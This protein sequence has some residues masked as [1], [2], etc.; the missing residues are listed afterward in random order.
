MKNK[1]SLYKSIFFGPFTYLRPSV[2]AEAYIVL[3]LLL[4]QVAMLFITRSYDSLFIIL[5]SLLAS[6]SVD[7]MNRE[8]NYKNSFV[9]IAS[10]I[11]ALMTGLLLPSNF[12]PVAVFFIAFFVLF[13]N[14]HTLGGFANSWVN[15]AA[16]TVA[17]CWIIGVKFF[18]ALEL[19]ATAFQSKNMALV[20]IQNGTFPL[21]SFDIAVTNFL[22]RRLFSFFG[23]SIPE[24]YFS[25]LWDSHSV[26]PAFRFN[27]L[28]IISSI[29]LLATDVLNPIIPSVF[30][31][32]YAVL[33]KIA[34]PLFYNGNL[35][36]G[37][38]ILALLTSGTLFCTFFLLQ[39]HGTT[40]FS[41][42]GK[43]IYG[44]LA[45]IIAF[46]ILGIGLSPAG[47]AFIILIINIL[48]L[49][50]QSVENHFLKEYTSS[51]LMQQVKSV[52][53]GNDA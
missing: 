28:T 38:M 48:S 30:I 41:N 20:L 50:I 36:Q 27:L 32:T 9:I 24:G 17:I 7:F 43:F 15:P 44:L 53:E 31:F 45:G 10:T 8:Q 35:F 49:L 46:F 1:E 12:P 23:V 18:P 6:Y 19:P 4:L 52:R 37:D 13:I 26:I 11:R 16:I 47:F 33:V 14:K 51:V 25:L 34:A 5:A 40:P 3:T 39:W 29:V 2:R 21:N 42:R 22:N